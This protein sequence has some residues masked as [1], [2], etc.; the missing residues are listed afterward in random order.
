MLARDVGL[1]FINNPKCCVSVALLSQFLYLTLSHE[2]DTGMHGVWNLVP[3]PIDWLSW[4]KV[5]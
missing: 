3:P 2:S 1:A 5:L 4:G